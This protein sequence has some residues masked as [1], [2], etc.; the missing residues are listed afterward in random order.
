MVATS[1]L[2][3]GNR[4]DA[5]IV[6]SDPDVGEAYEAVVDWGDGTPPLV[7]DLS[8]TRFDICHV[9]SAPGDYSATVTVTDDQGLTGSAELAVPA[10]GPDPYRVLP[11]CLEP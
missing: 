8:E 5:T 4:L 11:E 1:L 6:I 7:I 10:Q 3:T 9:Y 2:V